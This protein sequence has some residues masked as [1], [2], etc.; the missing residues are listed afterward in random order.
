MK[1]ATRQRDEAKQLLQE[2]EASTRPQ[3]EQLTQERDE[4]SLRVQQAERE[5]MLLRASNVSADAA[6][7]RSQQEII[8]REAKI[9]ALQAE[10]KELLA[11]LDQDAPKAA[12][13]AASL[14]KTIQQ[15]ELQIQELQALQERS[16]MEREEFLAM[17]QDLERELK[18]SRRSENL[19]NA[20][21]AA[22]ESRLGTLKRELE[23]AYL[24]RS[25]LEQENDKLNERVAKLEQ[26]LEKL[27]G[28]PASSESM[29]A[30]QEELARMRQENQ[31]LINAQGHLRMDL[32]ASVQR[33]EAERNRRKQL[34]SQ[35]DLLKKEL[36]QALRG[37]RLLEREIKELKEAMDKATRS[38]AQAEELASV[39]DMVEDM[40]LERIALQNQLQDQKQQVDVLNKELNEE[41]TRRQS[42]LRELKG[43]LGT[44]VHELAEAQKAIEFLSVKAARLDT[45]E[46]ERTQ[47]LAKKVQYQEDM[48]VLARH[49]RQ[50]RHQI[51]EYRDLESEHNRV[52]RELSIN[53]EQMEGVLKVNMV[54]RENNRRWAETVHG[55]RGELQQRNDDSE[56]MA[57]ELEQL[58]EELRR[59]QGQN[60]FGTE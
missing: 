37:Q 24:E 60:D 2:L 50:L 46:S 35:N 53:E 12:A 27:K 58:R 11:R 26:E 17:N 42:E 15:R 43:L 51:K 10:Q 18:Q 49:I 16:M 36:R 7:Q 52:S 45:V 4:L 6:L 1:E 8:Q 5:Q 47:L 54:L 25:E 48:K 32:K 55:L 21:V 31:A 30:L 41:Q 33:E 14:R 20:K 23:Q 28:A 39:R 9:E 40:K 56:A 38:G 29:Q 57:E 44:R 13:E 59:L 19:A 3:V 22:L 34:A